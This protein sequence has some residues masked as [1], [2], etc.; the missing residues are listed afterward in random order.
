MSPPDV[1]IA[2]SEPLQFNFT[3][4]P[5]DTSA[6]AVLAVELVEMMSPLDEAF[7]LRKS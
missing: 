3:V 1:A 6:M 5:D 4:P 7:V 2:L